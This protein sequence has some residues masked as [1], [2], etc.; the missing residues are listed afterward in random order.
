MSRRTT[1]TGIDI[2]VPLD[3]GRTGVNAPIKKAT[4]GNQDILPL[5]D[6]MAT[7]TLQTYRAIAKNSFGV[8]LKNTIGT[9]INSQSTNVDEVIDSIDAQK[10]YYKKARTDKNLHLLYL[11]MGRNQPLRLQKICT[12]P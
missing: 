1:D 12:M 3:T 2:N 7:R 11:R 10:D 8:E 9:T 4:G 6:T 5:F